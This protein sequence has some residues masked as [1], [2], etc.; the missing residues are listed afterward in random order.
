MPENGHVSSPVRLLVR[1]FESV[2]SGDKLGLSFA[3][4]AKIVSVLYVSNSSRISMFLL[5]CA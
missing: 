3:A 1:N 2:H 4:A 5:L